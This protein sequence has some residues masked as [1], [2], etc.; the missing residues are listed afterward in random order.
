MNRVRT[1]GQGG[2]GVVSLWQTADGRLYAVKQMLYTWNGEHF[3]RFK[4]EV[5][6]LS[7]LIHKNII[8]LIN[9]DIYNNNPWYVMPYFKDGSLRDKLYNLQSEGLIYSETAGSSLIYYLADALQHAHSKNIIH[10]D[11]KPENILFDGHEPVIADWGIGKFIH[12]E[13]QVLTMAGLGTKIYCSPEQ[14]N[15]G[16]SDHRSDI[17]SL[18]V[19]YREL[20]TGSIYGKVQDEKVNAII[21]RMTMMSPEDRYQSMAQ[22]K[23]AIKLLQVVNISEPMNNFWEGAAKVAVGAG[24]IYLLAKLFEGK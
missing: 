5:Q 15:S 12:K 13:S 16:V 19:I 1:I 7:N 4:R 18:G 9:F 2:L 3:E 24:I 10:R 6:I 8:R 17:F 22:V 14:W 20:L 21:N 11:L 23:E